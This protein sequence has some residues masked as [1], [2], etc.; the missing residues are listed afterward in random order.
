M[1]RTGPLQANITPSCLALRLTSPAGM[2]NRRP[3]HAVERHENWPPRQIGVLRDRLEL[4]A[5]IPIV[6]KTNQHSAAEEATWQELEEAEDA[7]RGC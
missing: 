3:V 5:T 7:L 1:G 4:V 6:R 2:I